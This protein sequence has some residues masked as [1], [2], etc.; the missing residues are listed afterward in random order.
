VITATISN[1]LNDYPIHSLYAHVWTE[2][3]D[4]LEWYTTRGFTQE[5]SVVQ[6][7]YRKLKPDTAWVLRRNLLPS[8]HLRNAAI[9][10][11]ATLAP[12]PEL[13][14][15]RAASY[16]KQR[17]DMEWNDLPSD[18]LQPSRSNTP[19]LLSPPVDRSAPPS[20]AS[21]RSSSRNGLGKKK[22]QYPAGAFEAV[23]GSGGSG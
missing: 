19:N 3:T 13:G 8:D 4:G 11:Q 10:P 2:N 20:S 9:K 21:S 16:Q 22:R 18:I 14:I 5:A 23:S 7:Y 17:P 12:K 1:S 6:N 15:A